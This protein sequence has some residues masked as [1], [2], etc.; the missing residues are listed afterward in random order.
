[1]T[2]FL[3]AHKDMIAQTA[4]FIAMA[5]TVLSFQFG[6]HRTIMVFMTLSSVFW[7]IHYSLLGLFPAAAI[8]TMN[9]LRNHIF[10]LRERKGWDSPVIPAVFVVIAAVSVIATWENAWDILPL[11]ASVTATVANW[12][13]VTGKLKLLSIPRYSL[14]VVYDIHGKAWAGLIN[15]IFTIT[16]I[17]ISLIRN[18]I[19]AN[20]TKIDANQ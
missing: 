7:V 18:K 6:K 13:K 12:Q 4:G 11:A 20:K 10:G 15:D 16:S 5:L 14:W 3:L 19:S 8:N 1:M 2:D 17:I 9:M